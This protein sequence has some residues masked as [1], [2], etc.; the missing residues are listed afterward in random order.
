MLDFIKTILEKHKGED[1]VINL[2]SAMEEI[3]T[4]YPKHSVPKDQYNKKAEQLKSAESTIK[5]LEGTVSENKE[6]LSKIDEYQKTAEKAQ[7]DLLATEKSYALK[8]ALQ[9]AGAKDLDYITFKLGE[10]DYKD[11][12]FV[13]L[14]NKLKDLKETLP[15]YFE[16]DEEDSEETQNNAAGYEVIDN[17]LPQGA[18]SNG[19]DP[20]ADILSDL[21]PTK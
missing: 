6:A 12:K 4:E 9:G 19:A 10:V 20:F 16:S 1:G 8:E 21:Q 2:D 11:G 5:E 14:D 7:A 3:K 15:N 18:G 13:D 17:G